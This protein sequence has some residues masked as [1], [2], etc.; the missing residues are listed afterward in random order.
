MVLQPI[1]EIVELAAI[2]TLK[3]NLVLLSTPL[4]EPTTL[5]VEKVMLSLG[6]VTADSASA[7]VIAS[8]Q[9]VGCS[10]QLKSSDEAITCFC[11]FWSTDDKHNCIQRSQTLKIRRS[12]PAVREQFGVDPFNRF[13]ESVGGVCTSY[14]IQLF[15]EAFHCPRQRFYISGHHGDKCTQAELWYAKSVDD[16]VY[17]LH[18]ASFTFL[19]T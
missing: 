13:H 3:N 1:F 15:N 8:I 17:I 6:I 11:L 16:T 7:D 9:Y 4:Q 19:C 18:R 10:N 5:M 14:G 2:K 12:F